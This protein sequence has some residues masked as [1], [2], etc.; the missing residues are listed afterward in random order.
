MEKIVSSVVA[1]LAPA[2]ITDFHIH[3]NVGNILIFFYKINELRLKL[4]NS[5]IYILLHFM[6]TENEK[7]TVPVC[8]KH[9]KVWYM[10]LL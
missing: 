4:S 10:L 5:S 2:S 3:G 7:V 9:N 6:V 8:L 1:L